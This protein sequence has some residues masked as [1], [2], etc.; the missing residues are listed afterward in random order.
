MLG[1]WLQWM[2]L[3]GQQ[4]GA[5]GCIGESPVEKEAALAMKMF[6]QMLVK[7]ATVQREGES[8]RLSL[9]ALPLMVHGP[10]YGAWPYRVV[11]QCVMR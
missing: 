7:V 6:I 8:F 2:G 4:L 5:A 1:V 9:G 11:S 10:T 3:A